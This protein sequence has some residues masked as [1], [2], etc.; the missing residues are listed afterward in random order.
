MV[1]EFRVPD[2]V[3]QP[4]S[5]RFGP[6]PELKVLALLL[7]NRKHLFNNPALKCLCQ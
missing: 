7:R 6:D 3:I 2:Q 4:C 5:P 1:F